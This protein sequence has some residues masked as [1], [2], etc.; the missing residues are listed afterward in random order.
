VK[1]AHE[2][3][4]TQATDHALEKFL[5]HAPIYGVEPTPLQIEQIRTY[6]TELLRWNE[7]INLTA[8]KGPEE[9]LMRHVLDALAP[10]GHLSD[11]HRLLDIGTGGGLPGI[12][13]KVFRPDILVSLLE[14]RRKK[15]SFNQHVVDRLD[16]EGIEVIWGR[17]GDEEINER[18]ANRPFDGMVTRAALSAAEVLRLG[19][20][21]LQ[22]GGKILLMMGTIDKGQRVELQEE[23]ITQGRSVVQVSPYRLPGF[24]RTRNLVLIS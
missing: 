3:K 18:Y 6:V 8:A 2:N 9:V 4:D 22:P 21:I 24:D 11:V 17:L 12:P 20:R 14:A 10:L 7:K 1:E 13:I 15:V 5:R 23:A 16:L 19:K